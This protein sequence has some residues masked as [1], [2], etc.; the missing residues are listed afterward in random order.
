VKS[1]KKN[2]SWNI[3]RFCN[4]VIDTMARVSVFNASEKEIFLA[5]RI[6]T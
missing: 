1:V 3:E 6:P 4:L 2:G 5:E